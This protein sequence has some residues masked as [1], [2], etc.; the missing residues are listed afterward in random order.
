MA[1][2]L[3]QHARLIELLQRIGQPG[4]DL[5]IELLLAAQIH[6]Y[7]QQGAGWRNPET[8]DQWLHPVEHSIQIGF[9][10]IAAVDHAQGQH[11]VRGQ[12]PEQLLHIVLTIDGIDVQAGHG[13]VCCQ[14][15][16]LGQLAE[17]GRRQQLDP[18]A[19]EV[20][21]GG[22]ERMLPVGIEFDD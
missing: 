12:Q 5:G 14:V 11:L 7:M 13:K 19:L 20:V 15:L 17:I 21:V 4:L 22:V 8:L 6:G 2:S 9:P 10:D 18:A 16:V 1:Q 3:A